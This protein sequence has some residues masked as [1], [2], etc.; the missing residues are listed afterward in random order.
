MGIISSIISFVLSFNFWIWAVLFLAIFGA[1]VWT[2]GL[3]VI[4][5]FGT[6]AN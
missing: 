2:V 3:I 4:G 5:V 1:N 6:L